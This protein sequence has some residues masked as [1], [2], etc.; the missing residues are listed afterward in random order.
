MTIRWGELSAEF[1]RLASEQRKLSDSLARAQQA[2]P[3]SD[4]LNQRIEKVR[5]ELIET[6]SKKSN[7]SDIEVMLRDMET[8]LNAPRKQ[9]G[10]DTDKRTGQPTAQP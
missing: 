3:G 5:S 7:T 1:E 9:K 6:L 2:C 4:T 10:K 8:R